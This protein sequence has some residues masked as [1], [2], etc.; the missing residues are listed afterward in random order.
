[1]LNSISSTRS[2]CQQRFIAREL[3]SSPH[4]SAMRCPAVMRTTRCDAAAHN[5]F[6]RCHVRRQSLIRQNRLRRYSLR[7]LIRLAT[8]ACG[9]G[10]RNLTATMPVQ[11]RRAQALCQL[12]A[13]SVRE[14][15]CSSVGSPIMWRQWSVET[16]SPDWKNFACCKCVRQCVIITRACMR[17]DTR[18]ASCAELSL[19]SLSTVS[20]HSTHAHQHYC[21]GSSKM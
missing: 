6:F 12:P 20:F 17:Q 8:G 3:R 21:A 10:A 15:G 13:Q 1:M 9:L 5:V 14:S 19:G 11:A 7:M 2:C 18:D 16:T 4:S